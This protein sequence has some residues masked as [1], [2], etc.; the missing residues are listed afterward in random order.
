MDIFKIVGIG[1]IATATAVILRPQK[2]EISM[3]IAIVAGV[4]IF[5]MMIDK[6]SA[7][8]ELMNT[9]AYK[10]GI[11]S[12]FLKTIIKI[13]GIAYVTEFAAGLCKDSGESAVAT[14]IEFGGKIIV[15]TMAVPILGALLNLLIGIMP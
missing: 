12:S 14:K 8:I 9:F 13:T 3:Q 7:V 4:L 1:L 10:A 11:E 2:P 6:L 15:I 5:I